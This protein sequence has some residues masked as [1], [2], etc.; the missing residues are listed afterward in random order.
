MFSQVQ[1]F[2]V[3]G[4]HSLQLLDVCKILGCF[5][6]SFAVSLAEA[7]TL[8]RTR[9]A[10]KGQCYIHR[11][12]PRNALTGAFVGRVIMLSQILQFNVGHLHSLKFFQYTLRQPMGFHLLS[13]YQKSLPLIGGRQPGK[14]N[15]T[16]TATHQEILEQKH[17]Q[18]DLSRS[19]RSCCSILEIC[20][21]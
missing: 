8:D 17:L 10:W 2:D 16:S 21:L 3:G 5:G 9:V 6:V 15:V 4:S 13:L 19:R 20:I 18:S 12:P 7:L 14:T 11:H 1:Q